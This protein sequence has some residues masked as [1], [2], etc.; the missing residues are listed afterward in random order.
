[1]RTGLISTLGLLHL[2][3]KIRTMRQY[4][5]IKTELLQQLRHKGAMQSKPAVNPAC[6]AHRPVCGAGSPVLTQVGAAGVGWMILGFELLRIRM[7]SRHHNQVS[8]P[9]SSGSCSRAHCDTITGQGWDTVRNTRQLMFDWIIFHFD[10]TWGEWWIL[11]TQMKCK[12][13]L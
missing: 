2:L 6:W 3:E 11:K 5:M 9:L 4:N 7:C 8:S 12:S 10:P 13:G 1:M